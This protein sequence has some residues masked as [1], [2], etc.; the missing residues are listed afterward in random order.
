[1]NLK[2]TIS[3]YMQLPFALLL[4]CVC[5]ATCEDAAKVSETPLAPP[6]LHNMMET[7]RAGNQVWM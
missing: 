4:L 2:R 1:M 5:M 7:F 3:D 6:E